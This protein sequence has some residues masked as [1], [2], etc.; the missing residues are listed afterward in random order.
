[1]NT[2]YLQRVVI[3]NLKNI[4]I[5]FGLNSIKELAVLAEVERETVESWFSYDRCPKLK[6]LDKISNRL[7]FPTY[8][9]LQEDFLLDQSKV[10]QS[11]FNDSRETLVKNLEKEYIKRNKTSWNDISSIYS[12]YLSI[13]TLKSYHRKNNNITPPLKTL[14]VMSSYLGIPASELI[15]EVENAES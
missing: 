13:D 6:T 10:K 4:M 2:S 14:E 7:N 8:I 1:M 15:K 12:G 9:L 11:I 3:A 5:F